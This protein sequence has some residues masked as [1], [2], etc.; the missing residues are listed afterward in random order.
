MIRGFFVGNVP[1]IRILV[2]WEGA[3]IDTEFILDTGFSGDMQITP[4]IARHL[5]ISPGTTESIRLA[6]GQICG[7]QAGVIEVH[8]EGFIEYA[9]ANISESSP[10]AGIGFLSKFGYKAIIDCKNK[11]VALE[12]A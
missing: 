9:E 3:K 12:K 5:N 10:L 4:D 11:T 2:S 1:I 8:A 7:M 6:S